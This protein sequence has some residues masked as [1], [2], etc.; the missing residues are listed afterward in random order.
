[1]KKSAET[2]INNRTLLIFYQINRRT[3]TENFS[4]PPREWSEALKLFQH[5]TKLLLNNNK[6]VCV[7]L[8]SYELFIQEHSHQITLKWG[9]RVSAQKNLFFYYLFIHHGDVSW[10]LHEIISSSSV[11]QFTTIPSSLCMEKKNR[12]TSHFARSK[13]KVIQ[14]W[15]EWQMKKKTSNG[16]KLKVANIEKEMPID[17]SFAQRKKTEK[18]RLA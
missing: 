8:D 3:H 7:C 17:I 4:Q 9:V 16:F 18:K 1:M 13:K 12:L 14:K 5:K 10:N 11:A 2:T 15:E 6:K